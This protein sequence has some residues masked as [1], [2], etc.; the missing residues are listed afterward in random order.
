MSRLLI[1]FEDFKE[2]MSGLYFYSLEMQKLLP[3][4]LDLSQYFWN[5]LGK[6]ANRP[7]VFLVFTPLF[8][9]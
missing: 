4:F 2:Q 9:E 7:F 8:L 1:D 5:K 3:Y 6:Q